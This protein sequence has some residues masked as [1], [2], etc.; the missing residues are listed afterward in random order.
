MFR[1]L[2]V[3]T[4]ALL[5]VGVMASAATATGSDSDRLVYDSGPLG[6]G[7]RDMLGADA[8]WVSNSQRQ[9]GDMQLGVAIRGGDASTTYFIYFQCGPTHAN[10]GAGFYT[11]YTVT[12]GA[13][14]R[15]NLSFSIPGST[16]LLYCGAGSGTGHI[17]LESGFSTLAVTGI[18][19]T[20]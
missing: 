7:A 5:A 18:E 15:G 19:W 17:D 9:N 16:L 8:G 4:A 11:G 14:G 10:A 3:L 2:L 1:R 20:N 13:N 6:G 12:T